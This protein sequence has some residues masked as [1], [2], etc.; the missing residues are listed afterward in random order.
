MPVG[1]ALRFRFEPAGKPAY[2]ETWTVTAADAQSGTL[3]TR[4]EHADGRIET[5]PPGTETWSN[6][7]KHA[8]FPASATTI[9]DSDVTTPAGTFTTRLYVVKTDTG[10][11][12]RYHFAPS[13]P[14]P[15][16]QLEMERDGAITMTMTMIGR[17]PLAPR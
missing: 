6:L 5:E 4:R 15:P 17:E 9:S 10:A 12:H 2:V 11:I 14:G 3:A 16:V 8:T 7:A 13:L 1:T